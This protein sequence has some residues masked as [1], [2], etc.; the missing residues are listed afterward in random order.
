[1]HLPLPGDVSKAQTHTRVYLDSV[2][3]QYRLLEEDLQLMML[4]RL[5]PRQGIFT[6]LLF[7]C[8]ETR[9]VLRLPRLP[10][11]GLPP[12]QLQRAKPYARHT[13]LLEGCPCGRILQI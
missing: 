11:V 12:I 13:R 3:L 5:L 10:I 8:C 7:H 9:K 4:D 1:M 2:D 6:V